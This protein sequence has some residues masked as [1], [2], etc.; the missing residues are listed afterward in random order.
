MALGPNDNSVDPFGIIDGFSPATETAQDIYGDREKED[1]QRE[2]VGQV[3]SL[4]QL[5]SSA[6]YFRL[7]HENIYLSELYGNQWLG[8]DQ[9]SGQII[10]VIG[11]SDVGV[12]ATN[13]KLIVAA[14]KLWGKLTKDQ[15]DFS[16][17]PVGTSFEATQAATAAET[18]IKYYRNNKGFQEVLD[19]CRFDTLWTFKGGCAEL[20]WDPEGGSEFYWCETC[21]YMYDGD[22]DMD[23]GPCPYCLAQHEE[24]RVQVAQAHESYNAAL[25]QHQQQ[26][27][28]AQVQGLPP[29]TPPPPP[30]DVPEPPI[31]ELRKINRGGPTL[32]YIDPRNLRF[33]SGV[34]NRAHVQGYVVREPF[35]VNVLRKHFPKFANVITSE[36]DVLPNS[37]A[38]WTVFESTGL[39]YSQLLEDHAYLYR[40]VEMP[41]GLYPHGRIVYICCQTVVGE[42]EGWFDTIGRLPLF[43]FG[44]IPEKGTPYFRPPIADASFRQ[45]SLNR[46]ETNLEEQTSLTARPKA[47]LPERC[48]V[49][50]SELTSQS[51][52]ILRPTISTANMIRYLQPPPI[53]R[54]V[55]ERRA[56]AIQDINT[57]FTVDD[58]GAQESG[59]A[60][61]L[62][63]DLSVQTTAPIVRQ[64]MREESEIY[65]CALILHQMFGDPE[66]TLNVLAGDKHLQV[67]LQDVSFS[68]RR[69]NVSII[70]DD[71]MSQ[72]PTERRNYALSMLQQ[73]VF[74]DETGAPDRAAFLQAAGIKMPGIVPKGNKVAVETAMESILK[75]ARGETWEP[76]PYDNAT[77]FADVY[78]EWLTVNGR[79]FKEHNP[80]ALAKILQTYGYYQMQQAQQQMQQMQQQAQQ[81]TGPDGQ[82]AA[83]KG[84]QPGKSGPAQAQQGPGAAG[85]Q[86]DSAGSL[87]KSAD[88]AGEQSARTNVVHEGGPQTQSG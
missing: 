82:P 68:A 50:E 54:D 38:S 87:I 88:T 85:G 36:P 24:V 53:S 28:Q 77:V 30:P 43:R 83:T 20:L 33:I 15:P 27:A 67:Q 42:S 35:P 7:L 25:A 61:A 84:G 40:A 39:R 57:L 4:Y 73:G 37:G 81:T 9:A 29:A 10:Q 6:E 55:Y 59:R 78:T 2:L 86:K 19:D 65:R 34:T 12:V 60:V 48:R 79:T 75:Q 58:M 18:I 14:L 70:A 71:G 31:G 23:V 22:L 51:A 17:T 45:R 56:Q 80:P 76:A 3:E 13:N 69:A 16:V 47:I 44:W 32:S 74:T 21:G 66:E 41:S 64:H 63:T 11:D 26:Q 1:E 46:L 52:Q 8:V 72:N 5:A 62:V 49:S